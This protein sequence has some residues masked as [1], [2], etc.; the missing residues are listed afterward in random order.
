MELSAADYSSLCRCQWRR[1]T[2]LH[3]AYDVAPGSSIL[4]LAVPGVTSTSG[5]SLRLQY[6]IIA[7]LER[8]PGDSRGD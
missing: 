4:A 5:S 2:N 1:V 8:L 7:S 6:A 3:I